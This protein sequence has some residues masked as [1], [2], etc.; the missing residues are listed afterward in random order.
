MRS[1][2]LLKQT[3]QRSKKG[4]HREGAMGTQAGAGEGWF[5]YREESRVTVCVRLQELKKINI[6]TLLHRIHSPKHPWILTMKC[7]IWIFDL[8][9][10]KL[11]SSCY[12]KL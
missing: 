5:G 6:I 12:F 11:L 4:R 3:N 2:D 8:L 1:H 10:Y 9:S 7:H